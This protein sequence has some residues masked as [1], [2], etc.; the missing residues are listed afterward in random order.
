MT[1]RPTR[2]A[3]PQHAPVDEDDAPLLVTPAALLAPLRFMGHHVDVICTARIESKAKTAERRRQ[4]PAEM[5]FRATKQ[6]TEFETFFFESKK[7]FAS[8]FLSRS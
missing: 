3:T 1:E 5:Q 4:D 8:L 2:E 6:E 7:L